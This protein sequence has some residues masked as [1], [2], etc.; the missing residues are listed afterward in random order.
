MTSRN[1][2][3]TGASRGIGAVVAIELARRGHTVGCF[4]RRGS[5]LEHADV[6][7]A[8]KARLVP[9]KG[10]VLDAE[11]V[12][13]ALAA[14]AAAAGSVD[15][16]V[17]NAGVHIARPSDSQPLAEFGE[18]MTT[19]TTATFSVCQ[20]AYPHLVAA[21]GGL[22]V[23]M[24]SLFDKLGVRHNAAYCASKAA[25]AALGR[26]LAVEW[27]AMGIRVLTVAPGYIETDLNKDYLASEKVRTLLA[28]RIPTGGPAG[29]GQV[30]RLIASLFE[31]DI[32]FLT[33]ETIYLD[34]GQGM[35]H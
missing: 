1:I 8:L 14:F 23:N 19:N 28:S 13:A 10:D 20:Q 35:A 24:G 32:P 6:P 3:L 2:F 34:G 17:N 15:G 26:C 5:G 30:A 18:V 16:V 22:V 12:A 27:A 31:E 21:G 7:E 4:S 9:L 11:S 33:G 29:P 25:V